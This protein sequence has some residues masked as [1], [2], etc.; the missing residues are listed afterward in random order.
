[1]QTEST[2]TSAGWDF[3]GETV[4]GANDIWWIHEGKIYPRLWWEN[5]EP[6]ELLDI[7]AQGI[8][9]L[10]LQP[11]IENSLLAKLDTALQKLEDDNENNDAAAINL[12]DAF[13]NAVE[14]QRGKKISDTDAD[15]LIATAQEIIELLSDE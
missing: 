10:D 14:A 15:S 13:I 4:N 8:I 9:D 11:G 1:M 12:L 6:V 5:I 7:L 2:F 3:V